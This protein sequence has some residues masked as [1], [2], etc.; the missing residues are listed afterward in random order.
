MMV[1]SK[2][3]PSTS[4][5]FVSRTEGS[6]CPDLSRSLFHGSDEEEFVGDL[7]EFDM[8]GVDEECVVVHI[9]ISTRSSHT[10]C[11]DDPLTGP[12]QE[13][14]LDSDEEDEPQ[15]PVKLKGRKSKQQERPSKIIP[16]GSDAS[17]DDEDEDDD[18]DGPITM[19]N[20]EARS[21]A[22][23]AK[24]ARE[25]ELDAEEM[26]Q[27]ALAGEESGDDL[28]DADDVDMDEDGEG[29]EE[30]EGFVLPTAEE[31]E[32]EKKTGGPDVH[33]V[34]RRMREC[35]RVLGNFAKRGAKGRYVD[36]H[37]PA[38]PTDIS[39]P[40]EQGRSTSSS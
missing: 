21:R 3:M 27:A 5:V 31:R 23:D 14:D 7:D 13:L 11:S 24:A 34:Q 30:S 36:E 38:T 12:A 22:M 33:T 8:E 9:N 17:S 2:R 1:T 20:M 35:V 26:R 19:K 15:L 28:A 6:T 29:G 4:H 10:T 39:L 32:E 16:T 25:A 37:C 18:E 40:S